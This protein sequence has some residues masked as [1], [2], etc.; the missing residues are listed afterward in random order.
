[1]ALT[2]SEAQI[3]HALPLPL[4]MG[5]DLLRL[6]AMFTMYLIADPEKV[7]RLVGL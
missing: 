2:S 5:L 3:V 1:M 7:T 6:E 4:V